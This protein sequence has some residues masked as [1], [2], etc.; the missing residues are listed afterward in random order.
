MHIAIST[1]LA[2]VSGTFSYS[3]KLKQKSAMFLNLFLVLLLLVLPT[4]VSQPRILFSVPLLTVLQSLV[5]RDL[6]LQ[7]FYIAFLRKE[8]SMVCIFNLF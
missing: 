4:F 7:D 5:A 2:H 8:P 6:A 3:F 1:E